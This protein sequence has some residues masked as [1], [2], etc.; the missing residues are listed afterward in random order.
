MAIEV[1]YRQATRLFL[2][3]LRENNMTDRLLES[4]KQTLGGSFKRLIG[5][6]LRVY[7]LSLDKIRERYPKTR[8]YSFAYSAQNF[9]SFIKSNPNLLK[10][11]FGQAIAELLKHLSELSTI[12][13]QDIKNHLFKIISFDIDDLSVSQ[14]PEKI[15]RNCMNKSSGRKFKRGRRFFKFLIHANMLDTKHLPVYT[16]KI[17][18]FIEHEGDSAADRLE[19]KQACRIYIKHLTQETRLHDGAVSS[20][21]YHI[22]AFAQFIGNKKKINLISRDDILYYLNHLELKRGYSQESK[23]AVLTTI[24]SFFTLF[25][26]QGLVKANTTANIKIKKVKKIDKTTLSEEE[27]TAIFSAAYLKYQPYDGIIPADSRV[28]LARWLA[29][30]DWAIICLLVCTGLRRKEIASLKTDSIDFRQRVIRITGKGDNNYQVRE[31]IIPVT[32]PIALSAVEIY[33]SLRP[34]SIFDYL[35]LNIHFEPLKTYG[36]VEVVNNMK[37][38]LF[39]QKSLTIT[40]I[41]KSFVSLCAKKGIDPLILKEIM[42]HNSLATTMKYYLTVQEQ[43]LREVW[44]QNNP[45]LY[46]SKEEFEEWTI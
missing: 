32:E 35:F 5:S 13:K 14:I 27:L 2:S 19:L 10:T 45:L 42:G 20:K 44:E 21:Y 31:R 12:A 17:I 7:P 11:S 8:Q 25:A 3:H 22:L 26:A 4:Y 40:Q 46:F 1:N 43:Q 15:I 36:F 18:R 6:E 16:S 28:T 34:K 9:L 39:P 23:T 29:S 24:R 33:L 37:K 30:R 41:R 38:Q